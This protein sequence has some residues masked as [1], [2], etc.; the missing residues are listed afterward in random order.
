M[1]VLMRPIP[2]PE[3]AH[4]AILFDGFEDAFIGY[5]TQFNKPFAVYSYTKMVEK[6]TAEFSAD[7]EDTS[8]CLEDHVSEAIEYIDFN[9]VGAWFGESTPIILRDDEESDE[10]PQGCKHCSNVDGSCACKG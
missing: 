10:E 8:G 6:L 2:A 1:G 3:W 7:C 5:G 9:T 4:G